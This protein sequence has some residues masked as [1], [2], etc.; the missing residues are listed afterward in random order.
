[1]TVNFGCFGLITAVAEIVAVQGQQNFNMMVPSQAHFE[2][3]LHCLICLLVCFCVR[4][5]IS[6][7]W[8]TFHLL[9]VSFI[10]SVPCREL[11]IDHN[12]D[13]HKDGVY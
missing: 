10:Y 3:S 12:C 7:D 9:A 6:L 13:I 1:M 4:H 5:S 8:G 2:Q 11:S